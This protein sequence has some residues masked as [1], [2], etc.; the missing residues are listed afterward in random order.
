MENHDI[1]PDSE[2]HGL[3]ALLPAPAR[4]YAALA[5]FDRPI[6]WWLL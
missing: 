3:L 4:P 2:Y 1:I 5:R 6:G